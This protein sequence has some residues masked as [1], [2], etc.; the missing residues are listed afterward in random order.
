MRISDWSSD[1]CSS[2]LLE[3]LTETM[4]TGQGLMLRLAENQMELKPI[5]AR[6]AESKGGSE[7][8]VPQLR[9]IE[10]YLSHMIE[11]MSTG[12][13]E[14]IQEVRSEIRLLARTIA[15]LAEEYAFRRTTMSLARRRRTAVDI[16]PGFVDALSRSGE[17][18]VGK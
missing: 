4:R 5:L 9:N 3:A 16:W 1:V 11:E 13:G 8:L 2:D 15:A 6:L 7:A 18:R 17:R 14:M 10:T 12:R